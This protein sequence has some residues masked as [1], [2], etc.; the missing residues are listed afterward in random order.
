MLSGIPEVELGMDS[1]LKNIEDT[2]KA[3]RA[4]YQSRQHHRQKRGDAEAD[5]ML[6]GARFYNL[7]KQI[8]SDAQVLAEARQ[9]AQ[10][11]QDAKDGVHTQS[12]SNHRP[13]QHHS[14]KREMATDDQVM[15]RFKKR[16]MN[17]MKR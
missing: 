7:R 4:L 3:K 11:E 9:K 8:Q 12:Q 2:E 14:A 6:A 17:N 15:Q 13:Q 5:E 16:Q 1:R 10:Q